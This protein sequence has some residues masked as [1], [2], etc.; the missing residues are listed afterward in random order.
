MTTITIDGNDYISYASVS[1]ADIFLLVDSGFATWDALSDDDK[2][3]YLVSAT[4]LIDSQSYIEMA[5]TQVL[6][7]AIDDFATI[8]ILIA[9]AVVID[10]N[11]EIF[12][13]SVPEQ[14][15]DTMKAGSVE[16]NY[17]RDFTNFSLGRYITR[18]TPAVY[19]LISKYLSSGSVGFG[20]SNG[21]S[22]VTTIADYGVHF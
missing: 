20:F 5:N 18:W 16:I 3:K 22:G 8:C 12:G 10:G 11:S 14:D 7:L 4:R 2:G 17:F 21:T 15:V 19:A 13:Y 9:K 6:R 1:D